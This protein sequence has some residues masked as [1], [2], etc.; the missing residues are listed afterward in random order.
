[1]T[2]NLSDPRAYEGGD[3]LI[4]FGPHSAQER[5]NRFEEFKEQGSVVFFPSFTRH[6]VTPVTKGTRYSLVMWVLGKPWR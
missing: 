1:M 6:Q 5:F 4:D 3:L 2:L